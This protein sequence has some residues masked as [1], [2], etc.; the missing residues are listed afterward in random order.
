[1]PGYGFSGKPTETGWGPERIARAYA[2]LMKRLGYDRYVA[3]GGDWGA[4]IVERMGVQ[5][6][7]GL[8]AS[9]PTSLVLFDPTFLA[10]VQAGDPSGLDDEETR[11]F[12]ELL[13][14]FS[15][16]AGYA[17]ESATHPQALYGI[18][19]SPVGLAAWMIDHDA[20]SMALISASLS[21][22][23]RKA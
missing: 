5:A 17:I 10:A 11:I 19:D 21:T 20:T 18:A 2:E 22:G 14:F 8:L 15:T 1:M 4:E 12:D 16:D 6:P 7:P 3:T 23:P 9:T 13:L